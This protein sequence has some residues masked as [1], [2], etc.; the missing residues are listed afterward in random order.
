MLKQLNIL[1]IGLF[2]IL[3]QKG[4]TQFSDNNSGV[5]E[6]L[7][8]VFFTDS[9]HGWAAG[10]N[11]C[12]VKTTDAGDTWNSISLET[13]NT[14]NGISFINPDTG[15]VVGDNNTL[16]RT[17][18]GGYTWKSI[19]IP[20]D[21]DFT[22]VQFV[23][24]Q[25]GFITGHSENGGIFMNTCDG[26]ISWEYQQIVNSGPVDGKN[27]DND[28]R[29]IYLMHCSFLNEDIGILGGFV[30]S[31]VY[32]RHPFL[33]KT[34]DGGKTFTN[35]SPDINKNDWY[36]GKEI[37][38][39][40]YINENDAI[41]I[42]NSGLGSNFLLIS[43]YH[44]SS[45]EKLDFESNFHS[46]GRFF[47]S[48]FLGRFIGYFT[49]I[50][51]GQ[52][53]II[54]TIDQ[55]NSFMFLSPPTQNS[56]Y[57]SFFVNANTGYFVGQNGTIIRL[58]DRD[59]IVYNA[60]IAAGSPESDPPYTLASTRRNNK[61][62]QIHIY[63]VKVDKRREFEIDLKNSLGHSISVKRT[64]VKFY[65]DEI[66]IRIKTRE[67]GFETYFYSVNYKKAPIVN[68]K[69]NRSAFAQSSY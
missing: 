11:G 54:K 28:E 12:M 38:S 36:V 62:T 35:I 31:Y 23:N 29:D 52:T 59:N 40:N 45:F 60:G 24:Q 17:N 7:N 46:R 65:S 34:T 49:G 20:M 3:T 50:V 56:L 21:C 9:L 64:H 15:I 16:L 6:D 48:E 10:V 13:R 22:S 39:I 18:D 44:V 32:G 26:G 53:Q 4:I 2:V 69:I 25:V 41:A 67:L 1:L 58:D 43:D 57:D 66:R 19:Y 63:N 51:N 30:Y 33:C 61:K 14:I 47:S 8:T 27:K 55:G 37:V 42:V 5:H 68:G